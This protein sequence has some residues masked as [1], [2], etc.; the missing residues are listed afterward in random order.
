MQ[1]LLYFLSPF[2]IS[3]FQIPFLSTLVAAAAPSLSIE[4]KMLQLVLAPVVFKTRKLLSFEFNSET[5]PH[6]HFSLRCFVQRFCLFSL[7]QSEMS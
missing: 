5:L 2:F 6:F 4:M 1:C 3:S 7:V